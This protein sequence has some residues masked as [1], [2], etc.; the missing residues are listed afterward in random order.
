MRGL[1]ARDDLLA[2]VTAL[3]ERGHNVLLFGPADIGKSAVISA[4]RPLIH[5][6]VVVID[7]FEHVS[8]HLAAEIRRAMDLRATQ[9]LVATRSLDR[10]K[11]GAVRRIAW[12]FT[13]VRVP[14][15]PHRATQL[16]VRQAFVAAGIDADIVPSAW[17]RLTTD[18]ARG[19]PGRAFAVADA[20]ARAYVQT[21]TLPSPQAAYVAGRMRQSGFG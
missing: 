1:M 3:L 12:R 14:P 13:N 18:L 9:H 8:P 19:L 15:L 5:E 7:P 2:E 11:L 17:V 16:L 10:A 6:S 4:L 21:G 20:A